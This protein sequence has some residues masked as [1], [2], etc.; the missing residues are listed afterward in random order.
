MRN[1][2][3]HASRTV[4]RTC[5]DSENF[6][7]TIRRTALRPFRKPALLWV[8]GRSGDRGQSAARPGT[9][10]AIVVLSPSFL[11]ETT[12]TAIRA[13]KLLERLSQHWRVTVLTETGRPGLGD[14]VRVEVVSAWR[15]SRLLSTLNRLRLG[16]LKEL[17]LWPDDSIFWIPPAILRGYRVIRRSR[18]SAIVVFMM[19]YSAGLA[20]IALSKL[21]GLP[22]ILNL[23]DSPTCTDMHSFFPTRLHFLMSKALENHYARTADGLVYVSQTNLDVVKARV[24][25]R[26]R[27]KLHLVRYGA[28]A[29]ED[30]ADTSC[31]TDFRIVY[32]GG[33]SGW[34]S[35][36]EEREPASAARR[37]YR[38][39][40]QFGRHETTTLDQRTS[41]PAVIGQ[42]MLSAI[43]RN[44]HWKG[45][46]NLIV[47]GNGY[48]PDVVNRALRAARVDSVVTV[49]SPVPHD[50]VAAILRQADL[51]FLTL[52]RRVDRSQGGRISAKTYE[53]L[54]T[55]RPI[56]AATSR[57]ENWSYLADKPG[58]W[59]VE[60][61]DQQ[62][63]A[64]VIGDLAGAK[65]AGSPLVFDRRHL[66][67]QLSYESR[68]AEFDRALRCAIQRRHSSPVSPSASHGE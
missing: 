19:P 31:A 2:K 46:L 27:D 36:I 53:Y 44:P 55:D 17:I 63:M 25:A 52:P 14:S 23:D 45:R 28:D 20:G 40:E 59:L 26:D 3:K 29:E 15:P 9:V 8:F 51:L 16:K 68:A 4:L 43:T 66:H 6:A 1:M 30:S 60:P 42:A 24:A 37:I 33:M 57:G 21:C 58:V 35:L 12:P 41:S 67:H 50:Q 34:W 61:D 7:V 65:F 13:G 11:P 10:P 56:L 32:V 62:R 49:R 18:P 38:Q 54:A 47:Y 64:D 22:L 39:W 5:D 48:S